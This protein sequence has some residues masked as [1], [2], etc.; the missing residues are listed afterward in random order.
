MEDQVPR[1]A[2]TNHQA[3]KK[4]QAGVQGAGQGAGQQRQPAECALL[5]LLARNAGNKCVD[6]G[7][8]EQVPQHTS[9]RHQAKEKQQHVQGM[10]PLPRRPSN[11]SSEGKRR[12]VQGVMDGRGREQVSSGRVQSA[13]H[14]CC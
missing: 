7:R 1:R 11:I 8:K 14:C 5:L 10:K 12:E 3:G 9:T 13:H 4:Q 2:S 6:W